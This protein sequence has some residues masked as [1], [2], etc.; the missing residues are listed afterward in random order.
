MKGCIA[1]L[2][3]LLAV[4][5]RFVWGAYEELFGF[6]LDPETDKMFAFTVIPL[7]ILSIFLMIKGDGK[8]RVE[9]D[10]KGSNGKRNSIR[11][12]KIPKH[13]N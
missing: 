3:S 10:K 4:V 7:C 12:N 6:P 5:L 11:Y 8:N 2:S 9:D 13:K 1:I